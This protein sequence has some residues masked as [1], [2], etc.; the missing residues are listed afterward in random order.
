MR[1]PTQLLDEPEKTEVM[2]RRLL[3]RAYLAL[4]REYPQLRALALVTLAAQLAGGLMNFYALPK[5]FLRTEASGGSVS[6]SRWQL[7]GEQFGL[8]MATFLI[9]ETL[10]KIPLGWISDRV[11]RRP[12]IVLGTL[13]TCLNPIFIVHLPRALWKAIFPVRVVDGAGVAALWPPLYAAVGDLT[14]GRSRA[15]AM[16]VINTVYMGAIGLAVAMG[17]FL[18]ALTGNDRSPFYLASGLLFLSSVVSYLG[19]RPR[20]ARAAAGEEEVEDE[21]ETGG[22]GGQPSGP[23]VAGY[24]LPLVLVLSFLMMFGP[25]IVAYYLTPYL[26][27]D[28][29]LSNVGM[30][31]LL[32]L[33]GVPVLAVG[34]PLGRVADRWGTSRAVRMSLLLAAGLMWLLPSCRTIHAFAAATV[35]IVLVLM[36]GAPAWLALVSGLARRRWRGGVMATVATAEG[37]GAALGPWVGGRLWDIHPAY[38]FYGAATAL[39]LAAAVA[40]VALRGRRRPG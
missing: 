20:A 14:H 32:L 33:M 17:G 31:G 9:S 11:G 8:V 21:E 5:Y 1:P 3:D 6:P 7:T 25:L 37:C 10:L 28:L 13:C 27:F 12:L 40:M 24:S 23:S 15:A 36:F 2:W 38:V 19:L 18:V 30:G 22:E 16:S 29:G 34:P 39:S 4:F 26:Q 35:M